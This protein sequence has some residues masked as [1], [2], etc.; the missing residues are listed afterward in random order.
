MSPAL[1]KAELMIPKAKRTPTLIFSQKRIQK[2]QEFK[3]EKGLPKKT[4]QIYRNVLKKDK[5]YGEF[6]QGLGI[7]R[8]KFEMKEEIRRNGGAQKQVIDLKN[9]VKTFLEED[10]HSRIKAG[11]KETITRFKVK[12][13]K[14]VFNDTLYNLHE[15]FTVEMKCTL[16]YSLFCRLRPFWRLSP[17][18]K[19]R[20]VCICQLH[21]NADL[22]CEKL[23]NTELLPTKKSRRS[24][25]TSGMQSG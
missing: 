6:K 1:K 12:K 14:R 5:I 3:R 18:I 13:Q 9:K 22:I 16:S 17:T 11:K 8:R 2:S 25:T 7:G 15:R 24:H 21:D 23:Y 10:R 4:L 20:E 19:D